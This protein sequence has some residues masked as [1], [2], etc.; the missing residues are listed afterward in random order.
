MVSEPEPSVDLGAL[1]RWMDGQSLPSGEIADVEPVGGGTQN[2]MLRFHRGER[3]YV[4]RR[5]PRHLRPRS[6]DALRR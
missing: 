6:N 1:S 5:G 3:E 2:V 4:L